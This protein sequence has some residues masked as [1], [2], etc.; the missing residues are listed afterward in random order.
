L[1]PIGKRNFPET[2]A[3]GRTWESL[4]NELRKTDDIERIRELLM[5]LE[6][7]IFNRQQELVRNAEKMDKGNI[8][9]EEQSLKSAL[10]LM[11]ELKTKRLGF[12]AIR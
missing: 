6:E 9:Q 8:E 11:L 1:A 3:T 12:P 5:L 4:V 10:D 7:A 2:N